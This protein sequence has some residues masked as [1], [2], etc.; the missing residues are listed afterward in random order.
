[1]GNVYSLMIGPVKKWLKNS[2]IKHE[3]EVIRNS[4]KNLAIESCLTILDVTIVKCVGVFSK[5]F[6][7]VQNRIGQCLKQF[8]FGVTGNIELSKDSLHRNQNYLVENNAG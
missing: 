3:L 4:L 7:V 6:A 8:I 5:N 2:T 1:M